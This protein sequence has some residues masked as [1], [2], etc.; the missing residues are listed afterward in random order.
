MKASD[1]YGSSW[2][3]SEDL[4]LEQTYDVTITDVFSH[5]FDDESSSKSKGKQE[6][7]KSRPQLAI[8]FEEFD[9]PL[10]LNK[11]NANTII[12]LYGNETDDWIGARITI[13]VKED[14][15]YAGEV[16]C[17][18]RVKPRAPKKPE[19]KQRRTAREDDPRESRRSD[20]RS[21]KRTSKRTTRRRRQ[22]DDQDDEE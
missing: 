9:K 2:L 5:T 16:M 1:F 7:R 10:S 3:K 6:K 17:G 11:V 14:V 8:E 21:A 18:I 13:Y 12:S 22:D 19:R 20:S 4:E 15:E